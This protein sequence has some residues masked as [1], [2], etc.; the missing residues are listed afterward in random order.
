VA[1]IATIKKMQKY[2][3]PNELI[4]YGK[5]IK[6][7][8][9]KVSDKNNIKISISGIDPL[10]HFDFLYENPL[11]FKT[12]VTQEMLNSGF[13][14]T[15]AFYSCFSHSNDI[16]LQYEKE[17]DKVFAKIKSGLDSNNVESL[18][19]GEICHSGFKRL[20]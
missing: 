20:N 15:T 9:K 2:N 4:K 13:L 10:C 17:I 14:A 8:W 1:A 18:L 3:V 7:I 6:E 5:K 11:L 16:L 19:K 12:F